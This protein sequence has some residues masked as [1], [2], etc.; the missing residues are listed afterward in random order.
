MAQKLVLIRHG[1]IDARYDGRFIGS[2]DVPLADEGLAEA[3]CLATAAETMAPVKCLCSPML[4]ARQ[5]ADA[6][7][8]AYEI[9]PD[10]REICF[11]RWECM[12]FEEI[13]RSEPQAV[14]EW[15]QYSI[16]FSFP[17]GESTRS[18]LSRVRDFGK[19]AVAEPAQTL[20]AVTHAGV[21]RA[22][23]CHFLDLDPRNYLLFDVGP[24]SVS[25]IAIHDGKGVLTQ[26]N[27]LCHRRRC[28]SG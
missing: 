12:T 22:L 16:D 21:I 1:H 10:L 19:R 15:A 3:S 23:I 25:K 8:V 11:G 6:M 5:T 18:F 26:L 2:T 7:G 13:R 4:R 28:S 9:H 27:D 24:S 20:V 14:S 17:E